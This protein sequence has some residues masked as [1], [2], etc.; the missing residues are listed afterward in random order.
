MDWLQRWTGQRFPQWGPKKGIDCSSCQVT[1]PLSRPHEYNKQS[2]CCEFSPFV[3]AFALGAL[4]EEGVDLHSFCQ[5]SPETLVWT[6]LGVVH[7][8]AH[9][10][11]VDQVCHFFHQGKGH[12]QIWQHRPAT[13]MSFFCVYEGTKK[14]DRFEN[15]LLELE[16]EALL[17]WHFASGGDL[18]QWS[19][20]GLA[21]EAEP[22][23]AIPSELIFSSMDE[24]VAHYTKSW[25][26]LKQQ[27]PK[28]NWP[29]FEVCDS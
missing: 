7:S 5:Q 11:S 20:W 2:K 21:M 26:W 15:K 10:K 4:I 22:I 14:M 28:T 16:T 17:D 9:R 24:A 6:G 12:C 25:K 27:R 18:Q 29:F 23:V 1:A 19:Q 3:S 13:C 8:L